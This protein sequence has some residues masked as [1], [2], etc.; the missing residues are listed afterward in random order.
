[1]LDLELV[2]L[3]LIYNKIESNIKGK[4]YYF[5][6]ENINHFDYLKESIIGPKSRQKKKV[7]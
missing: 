1:M 6:W 7:L 3:T 2:V 5:T 4:Q